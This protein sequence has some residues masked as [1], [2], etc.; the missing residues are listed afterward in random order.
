MFGRYLPP[1]KI[2]AWL[3]KLPG[4]V[5]VF[6]LG[7]SVAG[8]PI[9]AL[10]F[11]TGP[12]KI[13]GWSQMHGNESTTTKALMDLVNLL[14]VGGLDRNY[15]ISTLNTY[16]FFFIP[17]L[18]P[19]GAHA[20]TRTNANGIDLNRDARALEQ[21]ESRVLRAYFERV[22]PDLCL[23]LHDQRSIYGFSNGKPAAL[24]FLAPAADQ[25]R[26]IT[27]SRLKA[28]QL[29]ERMASYVS[30]SIPG[31]IGRYD[32]AFNPNCVGDTFQ[33]LGVPTILFEAGHLEDDYNRERV[34]EH[35]LQ[36]FLALFDV[37]P[38]TAIPISYDLLPQ[39]ETNFCDV[40]IKNVV[41]QEG[42]EVTNIALHFEELLVGDRV[43]WVPMVT[44]IGAGI[45]YFGHKEIDCEGVEVLVNSCEKV[46][47]SEKVLTITEKYSPFREF[48]AN[49]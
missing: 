40:L 44:K 31:M 5:Q 28:M 41:L 25:A 4:L 21:P 34:R 19:D 14:T 29:I 18:N 10:E 20:Y 48:F 46:F 16:R 2:Q 22:D 49:S 3:G 17:Q 35:V 13:L 45:G 39:N 37:F 36:A 43:E 42:Q 15:T 11:G 6:E 32:D 27:P 30:L 1:D 8:R 26:T 9:Y 24:S 38:S 47:E 33:Q 7:F 12:K 23:N